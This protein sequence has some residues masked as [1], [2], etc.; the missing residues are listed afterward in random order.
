MG[1]CLPVTREHILSLAHHTLRGLNGNGFVIG[2]L[3]KNP[4]AIGLNKHYALPA[5]LWAS[6]KTKTIAPNLP[7][8]WPL[9]PGCIPWFM[10]A[11]SSQ[12]WCPLVYVCGLSSWLLPLDYGY[13]GIMKYMGWL[14]D[15]G[16]N[17]YC[18]SAPI[19]EVDWSQASHVSLG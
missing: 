14:M 12:K 15:E 5:F 11:L 8:W 13:H 9:V 19:K 1:R 3:S 7:G 4:T 10:D 18:L 17:A 2:P 6:E 16:T